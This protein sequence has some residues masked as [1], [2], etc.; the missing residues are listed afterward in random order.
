MNI[1]VYPPSK[2]IPIKTNPNSLYLRKDNWDDYGFKTLHHLYYSGPKGVPV[3]IGEVKIMRR[4]LVEREIIRFPPSPFT[5]LDNDY[6]SLG[7]E[8]SYY[9]ELMGFSK[10]I[11]KEIL[12]SLRDCVNDQ[13]IFLNFSQEKAMDVSLMRTV[14]KE[15]IERSFSTVLKGNLELSEFHFVYR[16]NLNIPEDTNSEIDIKVIPNSNPPTN[17]HVLIGRNGVGKTRI[18]SGIADEL[19]KNMSRNEEISQSGKIIF[20]D[21]PGTRER[22]SNLITIN[23]S[24]FD[25]FHPINKEYMKGSVRY[26]YVGLKETQENKEWLKSQSNLEGE[27]KASIEICL[28]TQRK[29]RWLEA[30]EIL[31][32]DPVLS[33][34]KLHELGSQKDPIGKI[35]DVYKKLSS[36][37]KI[38]LLSITKLV[39]LVEEKT[40]VLIDEPEIHLHPPL[41]ASYMRALS[42]LVMKRNG[43][44]IISTHSPVVLQEV[45]KSCVTIIE[46]VRMEIILQRPRVETFAENV[47]TLTR[48]VFR[49]EVMESGFYQM[50]GNFLETG[51]YDGLMD[52]FHNQIGAEGRAVARSIIVTKNKND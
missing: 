31:N 9:E 38:I 29:Q 35:L 22:F 2:K 1:F 14:T 8:Q 5:K 19:T 36:G 43:V 40:L 52:V 39:E 49:L 32:A 12:S 4:G 25:Q 17:I 11:R 46:R 41:L 30:I 45:P 48:E 10:K 28:N 16:L 13:K 15:K 23:F 18:L 44:A 37:H 6:C 50:I 33:E 24:A 47:G 51:S 34:Y 21:K 27:F 3:L 7:Q 26:T 20:K 42:D